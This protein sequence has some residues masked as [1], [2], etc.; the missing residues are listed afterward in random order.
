MGK[1]KLLKIGEV[2]RLL[3]VTTETIYNYRRREVDPIPCIKLG[4]AIRFDADDV[5]AW[6][7]K[8]REGSN[9]EA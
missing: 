2:A 5:D 4:G 6:I 9:V 1:K 7:K 8:Q 3:G